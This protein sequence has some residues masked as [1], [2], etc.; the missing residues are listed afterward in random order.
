MIWGSRSAQG[1]A[2]MPRRERSRSAVGEA[3]LRVTTVSGSGVLSMSVAAFAEFPPWVVLA[4]VL[5]SQTIAMLLLINLE[6]RQALREHLAELAAR[7]T[8]SKILPHLRGRAGLLFRRHADGSVTE[9]I[10]LPC[11]GDLPAEHRLRVYGMVA[12]LRR[13]A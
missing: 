10:L 6:R 13:A 1:R 4:L 8:I 12:E 5:G 2:S 11:D 3:V 9:V 7:E